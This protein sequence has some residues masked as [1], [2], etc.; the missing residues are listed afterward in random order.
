MHYTTTD[1]QKLKIQTHVFSGYSSEQCLGGLFKLAN[2]APRK[3]NTAGFDFSEFLYTIFKLTN[4]CR[5]CNSQALYRTSLSQEG[6]L[7]EN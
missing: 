5:F 3:K 4:A 1:P 6:T 2:F 7:R